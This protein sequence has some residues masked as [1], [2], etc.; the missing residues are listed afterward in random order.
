MPVVFI[1]GGDRHELGG[2]LDRLGEPTLFNKARE[3][4][5][6]DLVFK[7]E[8]KINRSYEK[9]V[10]AIT[11]GFNLTRLPNN[12]PKEYKYDVAFWAGESHPIRS[13]AFFY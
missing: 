9:K 4:R 13:K 1:D 11:F 5:D 7:R 3:I 2:D 10:L 6:F 12:L 8:M